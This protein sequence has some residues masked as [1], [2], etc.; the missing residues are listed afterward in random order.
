MG[1]FFTLTA[2]DQEIKLQHR[3]TDAYIHGAHHRNIV[4]I[5]NDVE[6]LL[7]NAFCEFQKELIIVMDAIKK[8]K[9]QNPQAAN[10]FNAILSRIRKCSKNAQHRVEYFLQIWKHLVDFMLRLFPNNQQAAILAAPILELHASLHGAQFAR[11]VFKDR[12]HC[13][14]TVS[15]AVTRIANINRIKNII[16]FAKNGH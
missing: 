8:E 11:M 9:L 16:Q 15:D 10:E 14:D 6:S 1:T 7:V 12:Y 3:I 2:S 13:A 5:V 4:N